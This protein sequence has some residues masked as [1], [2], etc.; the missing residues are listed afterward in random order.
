VDSNGL[1]PNQIAF[2]WIEE[3]IS[4]D[5]SSLGLSQNPGTGSLALR[6]TQFPLSGLQVSF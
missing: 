3:S 1:A 4:G 6:P 5:S 2:L